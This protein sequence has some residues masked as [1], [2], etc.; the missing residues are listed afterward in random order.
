MIKLAAIG[1]RRFFIFCA[2]AMSIA[3]ISIPASSPVRADEV[4]DAAKA[5]EQTQDLDLL[6]KGCST[7]IEVLS[8]EA[9]PYLYTKRG[10]AYADKKDFSKAI[11]DYTQL[12]AI[13]PA[14]KDGYLNRGIAYMRMKAA[15]KAL[16]DFQKVV[17]IEPNFAE[18]Y[19]QRGIAYDALFASENAIADLERAAALAPNEN[20]YTS[21]LATMRTLNLVPSPAAPQTGTTPPQ[22]AT[23]APPT[24]PAAPVPPPSGGGRLPGLNLL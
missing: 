2:T 14:Q 18:G 8:Q 7:L 15:D 13:I 21:A 16:A 24:P 19:Y 22:A 10:N 11:A 6:I 4:G 1:G 20:R 23:P 17:E 5:C 9:K 12:I 3:C